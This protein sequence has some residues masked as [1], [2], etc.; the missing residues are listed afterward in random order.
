MRH[1]SITGLVTTGDL[2]ATGDAYCGSWAGAPFARRR[3]PGC[4][5]AHPLVQRGSWLLK[6]RSARS[7]HASKAALQSFVR[8]MT[9]ALFASELRM[10][11]NRSLTSLS[12]LSILFLACEASP[13][14]MGSS[15]SSVLGGIQDAEPYV[16]YFAATTNRGVAPFCSGVLVRSDLV[17]TA[18]HCA[19]SDEP[20]SHVGIGFKKDALD[21]NIRE[22]VHAGRFVVHPNFVPR[23]GG[24]RPGPHDIA[25]F[26]LDE[27]MNDVKP[28]KV[29]PLDP[30]VD[31][32]V[33]AIGYGRSKAYSAEDGDYGHRRMYEGTVVS[34][35]PHIVV[36]GT[37]GTSCDGDSGGPVMEKG[38]TRVLGVLSYAG[39]WAC[40]GGPMEA[41]Q[42]WSGF[43]SL[44]YE[45]AFLRHVIN[46]GAPLEEE[47]PSVTCEQAQPSVWACT[48]HNTI[49]QCDERRTLEV[50]NCSAGCLE[51][52]HGHNAACVQDTPGASCSGFVRRGVQRWTCL[53]GELM[54]CKDG[55]SQV[56]H[57]PRGCTTSSSD[58]DD[59]CN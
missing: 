32:P 22:K 24:V 57:C 36:R 23:E 44:S 4:R 28:A 10:S 7:P 35:G 17:L 45:R 39:G 21:D 47:E 33:R 25:F 30:D 43:T 51:G 8:N 12:I 14:G 41:E 3:S 11:T 37:T 2:V 58:E 49:F 54:R 53:N 19:F 59:Y 13:D 34:A 42:A 16:V 26:V 18:A 5:A 31:A 38:T 20:R 48:T 9:G 15:T 40:G 46:H 6:P 29:A 50:Q 56:A 52:R 55:V 27:P 1:H